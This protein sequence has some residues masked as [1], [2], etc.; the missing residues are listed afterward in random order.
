LEASA[1]DLKVNTLD[2]S[3]DF[4]NK[5]IDGDLKTICNVCTIEEGFEKNPFQDTLPQEFVSR[6]T[7]ARELV[8]DQRLFYDKQLFVHRVQPLYLF[9]WKYAFCFSLVLRH[10]LEGRITDTS[11]IL[12]F[13]KDEVESTLKGNPDLVGFSVLTNS[14]IN[15]SLAIA[16]IVKD[17]FDIPVILGGPSLYNLDLNELM[18]T[19]DFIDFI[20]VKEGEEALSRLTKALEGREDFHDVPNLIWR[21][22][23]TIMVNKE[24]MITNLD[25]LPTPDFSDFQL[26]EY[27]FPELILPVS[28]ARD[29][30][31]NLCKFCQLNAQYGGKYR[32]RSIENVVNDIR[33]LKEKHNV[34]NFFFTDSEI[35]A[36]RLKEIGHALSENNLEAYFGCYA[37]PTRDLTLQVMQ[38]AFEGGCRFIQLGVESLND[39][40]LT[41]VN[42]GTSRESV[43]SALKNADIVGINLLCY[44]LAGIP[45]QT[46][47]DLLAD[48]K[49]IAILQH[50]Y[51]IF[52]VMY[53]LYNLGNHQPFYEQRQNYGIKLRDRRIAFS[54]VNSDSVHTNESL[55]YT[56]E[57]RS[58]YFLLRDC[59]RPNVDSPTMAVNQISKWV[60]ELGIN[61]DN[62]AFIFTINDFI[63]ETQLL[64]SKERPNRKSF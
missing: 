28:S 38:T 30:P 60:R 2:L 48:M 24:R 51:N 42:K 3:L 10:Y 6:F 14:Q 53:C 55:P 17:N 12:A 4:V 1:Q 50:Q 23:E 20:V 44:M 9:L 13:L 41:F 26:N 32:Q 22:G 35:T 34:N 49:E 46:R 39:K 52:S 43:L 61:R 11:S 27:F 7:A 36:S 29:C 45:T 8:K 21:E 54:T 64:Y 56:Y 25:D 47:T 63:F 58:A 19:F 33:V 62:L 37:R 16:K 31:W 5:V 18:N 57:D 40:F 59:D 15:F